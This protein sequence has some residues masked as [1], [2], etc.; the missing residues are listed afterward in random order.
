MPTIA[1]Q[2]RVARSA[3]GNGSNIDVSAITTP[4]TID[5]EVFSLTAN[6]TARITFNDSVNAFTAQQSGPCV[7]LQGLTNVPKKFTFT[8]K[9]FPNLR[10]GVAS[11]VIRA[12]A[13][14]VSGTVNYQ[15]H[16][17]Y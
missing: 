10:F 5:L 9:D 14:G 12:S 16:L 6:G 3:D 2:A 17:T 4:W 7:H 13:E 1:I 15:A 11:A 8:Q